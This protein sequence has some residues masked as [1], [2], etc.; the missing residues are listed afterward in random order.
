MSGVDCVL[1]TWGESVSRTEVGGVVGMV[2]CSG[3]METEVCTLEVISFRDVKSECW[4]KCL[5]RQ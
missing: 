1:F 3:E 5:S 2:G 4:L